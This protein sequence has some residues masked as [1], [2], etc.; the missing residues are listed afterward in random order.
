MAA[1]WGFSFFLFLNKKFGINIAAC[2][3]SFCY[4]CVTL[5]SEVL[6]MDH[7]KRKID[8]LIKD[9]ITQGRGT[10]LEAGEAWCSIPKDQAR[11]PEADT[12]RAPSRNSTASL[13]WKSPLE[14]PST[15]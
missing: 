10:R 1:L 12:K 13:R 5:V 4:A 3:Y 11:A 2:P 8:K 7:L 6:E 15:G 14:A 9:K